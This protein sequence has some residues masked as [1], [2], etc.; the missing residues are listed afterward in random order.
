[1]IHAFT[2]FIKINKTDM[3]M[4]KKPLCFFIR[5]IHFENF[6][7]IRKAHTNY[8]KKIKIHT[9]RKRIIHHTFFVYKI[10]IITKKKFSNFGIFILHESFE[11]YMYA[12][13]TV[14]YILFYSWF[15][16]SLNC[17]YF[18]FLFRIAICQIP[19]MK[20]SF[21]KKLIVF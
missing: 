21:L 12:H 4:K 15:F 14:N 8:L 11:K 1:M 18:Y 6:V 10:I 2:I 16:F 7:H 3:V 5:K 20:F 17:F 9:C 19:E 13:I